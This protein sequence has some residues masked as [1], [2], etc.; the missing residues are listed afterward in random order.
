M[1]EF[2]S[3]DPLSPTFWDERFDG[4]FTPWDRG[5]VPA[6]LRRYVVE[7]LTPG[8]DPRGQTL[9]RGSHGQGSD[10]SGLTQGLGFRVL[11]PGCG[12]GYELALLCDAGWDAT[13]IDFSPSAVAAARQNVGPWADH[14][15]EADFFVHEPV[16]PL[17]LIYERAFL[18]AMPRQMW[19]Q[20]AER[21][22][23]LLPEGAQLLGYFFFDN[24]EKG[25]PFGADRQQLEALLE[26]YFTLEQDEPVED[27]IPVF[28]GKER[29]MSWRRKKGL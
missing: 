20:V 14:V 15:V 17:D 24:N 19:P 8:S 3:R 1:P 2:R 5:D 11:I 25:P 12:A 10:T 26:P 13:A 6:R 16:R 28:L 23:Q 21:W 9:I 27:S 29:W 4:A 18:C 22:A 7:T